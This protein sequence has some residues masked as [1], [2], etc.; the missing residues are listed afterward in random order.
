[1]NLFMISKKYFDIQS[2]RYFRMYTKLQEII[3]RLKILNNL[4]DS[5]DDNGEKIEKIFCK[6]H[7]IGNF[8]LTRKCMNRSR[9]YW[10]L[11][12][13]GENIN[14]IKR[15]LCYIG[16]LS[17]FNKDIENLFK[18]KNIGLIKFFKDKIDLSKCLGYGLNSP[19]IPIA[20]YCRKEKRIDS[21]IKCIIS[22]SKD[23]VIRTNVS[24]SG[25]NLEH[26]NE[27]YGNMRMV[28]YYIL[29]YFKILNSDSY[30]VCQLCIALDNADFK[31]IT[32]YI[33]KKSI[34]K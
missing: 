7:K 19:N 23:I 31:Y 9:H 26:I 15:T 6:I 29:P 13:Q 8:E 27:A 3:P 28:K 2:I 18:C 25:G 4:N 33:K 12:L 24:L 10:S 34:F 5:M 17:L 22:I 30:R 14:H 20:K 21:S 16:L 32:K 1:M 11:I